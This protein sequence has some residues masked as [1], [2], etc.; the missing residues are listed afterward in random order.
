MSTTNVK[1]EKNPYPECYKKVL[2]AAPKSARNILTNLS[3]NPAR[4]T[5]L[6]PTKNFLVKVGRNLKK[7]EKH[8]VAV[9][10]ELLIGFCRLR[11]ARRLT[12]T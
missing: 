10:C 6:G 8:C 3:P 9:C 12:L 5:T 7:V 1:K 11:F 4:L 2:Y